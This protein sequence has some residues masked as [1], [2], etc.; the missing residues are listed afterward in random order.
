MNVIQ[1]RSARDF[2]RLHNLFVEYEEYLP[3]ELR[4]GTVPAVAELKATYGGRNAAFLATNEA[5]AIGCFAVRERD[6][7]TAV[8]LRLFV[9]PS[10]RGLGAARALIAAALEYL[11]AHSYTRAVLDTHKEQL[12]AAY[13]LYRSFGFEECE[14]YQSTGY[15][16]P[17]FMERRLS[18]GK[19]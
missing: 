12:K 4:H 14:P 15:A 11:G 16:S 5:R 9:K 13:D 3:A 2:A 17:T 8:L 6:S 19:T 1:V 18:Q 10:D 7:Q